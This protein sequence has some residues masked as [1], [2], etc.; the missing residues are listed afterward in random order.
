MAEA[1]NEGARTA[2]YAKG[3]TAASAAGAMSQVAVT[4]RLA[5]GGTYPA[6]DRTSLSVADGE[7]VAI[8]GPTGCGK[9]TL[10]NIAAG[11]IAPTARQVHIFGDQL[12]GLNR[13]AGYL[14]QAE[15]LF[16]W[17]SALDNI[18]IGLE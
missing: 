5:D 1:P 6:V 15:A 13:Q 9:S 14:F 3:M 16:P 17:K 18:A 8:V 7:F 11:L 10:L 4:F 2:P 12:R